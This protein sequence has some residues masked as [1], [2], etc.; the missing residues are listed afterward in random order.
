MYFFPLVPDP[1]HHGRVHDSAGRFIFRQSRAFVHKL[2]TSCSSGARLS[3]KLPFT[4]VY[5]ALEPIDPSYLT[6]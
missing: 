3:L 6:P 5:R 2:S 1:L 4:T